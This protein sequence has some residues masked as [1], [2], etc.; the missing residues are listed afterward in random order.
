MKY[1]AVVFDLDGTI[2]DSRGSILTALRDTVEDFSLPE[3]AYAKGAALIGQP[4]ENMLEAMGVTDMK[5]GFEVYRKHYYEYLIDERPYPGV[6]NML[7]AI[8]GRALLSVAT[9]K[10]TTSS[11]IILKNNKLLNKFDVIVTVD[12]AAA[13]PDTAMLDMILG[14]YAGEGKN[15]EPADVLIVG[16]S[17]TDMKFA[18][19]CGADGAFATWGFF[20]DG[21]NGC[22]PA[23][24]LKKP[25]DLVGIVEGEPFAPETDW[26][27]DL[28]TYD[29][30]TTKPLLEDYLAEAKRKGFTTVRIVHGNGNGVQNEIVHSVREGRGD[31][32]R[33][34]DAPAA[35]G[36]FGATIVELRE[37]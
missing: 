31:V 24:V 14:H 30:K 11:R 37:E 2:M 12:E 27:I 29:P 21:C 1:L 36:G 23:Y 32:A 34:Y 3:N 5:K 26:E 19:N 13:K 16:D 33:F 9:N 15:L 28:H 6:V 20:P 22:K 8:H 4:L 35:F 10:G 17:P 7:E 25:G 18:A